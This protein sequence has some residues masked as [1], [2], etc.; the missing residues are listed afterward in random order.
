MKRH[1]FLG[2]GILPLVLSTPVLALDRVWVGGSSLWNLPINWT[3]NT[4][5]TVGDN[6]IL[7]KAGTNIFYL[8]TA[9]PLL[10]S[11]VID[12]SGGTKL[13]QAQDAL[14]TKTLIVGDDTSGSYE[15][16]LG[17]L[18]VTGDTGAEHLI[19]G[20]R[21]NGSGSFSMTG[22]TVISNVISVG[23]GNAGGLANGTFVQSGGT[24]D[25]TGGSGELYIGNSA[26]A[27][28]TYTISGGNLNAASVFVAFSGSNGSGRSFV[29]SGGT[30]TVSSF[31][32]LGGFD[33]GSAL[34]TG[35][36]TLSGS[37]STVL[38]AAVQRIG[39]SGTGIF[40]QE[41]GVNNL[42][43]GVSGSERALLVGT[44]QP[45]ALGTYN[46]KNGTLN[47]EFV[48]VGNSGR[49]TFNH[50]G[51]VVNLDQQL[52]ID[53]GGTT[54]SR[55][56]YAMS[57]G[58]LNTSGTT[59]F[60]GIYNLG[61]LNQTGGVINANGAQANS[62]VF[63]SGTYTLSGGTLSGT[64]TKLNTGTFTGF[65]TIA[66]TGALNNEGA[67]TFVGGT[68]TVGVPI[69]NSVTGTVTFKDVTV[70]NGNYVN[71]GTFKFTNTTILFRGAENIDN[72]TVINDPATATYENNYTA[73]ASGKLIEMGTGNLW[74]F[75]LNVTVLSTQY[76]VWD[77]NQS[78]IQFYQSPT[79]ATGN[80]QFRYSAVDL[81][82]TYAG[83]TNNLAW[84]QTVVDSGN[85]LVNTTGAFYTSVL[86]LGDGAGQIQSFT[87]SMR[88]YYD[89]ALSQNSYLAGGTYPFGSGGGFVA[90]VPEPSAALFLTSGAALLGLRR[91]R[92]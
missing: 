43:L 47:A 14:T 58:T 84:G 73:G 91:R 31:L 13:L 33:G 28:G 76:S 6:A 7:D 59:Q 44:E 52:L 79:N 90:P 72:G 23:G 75:G 25:V 46:M 67:M 66:G 10:N 5:P 38:T 57:G 20:A 77:T 45:G 50:S 36:Y 87:G 83:F 48:Q 29:H 3:T 32:D 62:G 17:S 41:G 54:G 26:N 55:G 22:G 68:S 27:G 11:V 53:N 39:V 40:N 12:A 51:G 69:N 70:V 88:I 56:T 61:I 34:T 9:N 30:V 89:P 64:G 18:T 21:G 85:E 74:K 15:M 37:A 60:P 16:S 4:V 71:D 35:T 24:V 1:F 19:I 8:N 78:L 81:G 65:G 63:N 82:P 92:K 2:F 49:G 86:S 80:H 42:T